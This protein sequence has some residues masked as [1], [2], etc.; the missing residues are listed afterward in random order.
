M[1]RWQG[2]MLHH[3][4]TKDTPGVDRE[5]FKRYHMKV[6]RWDDIG[7]HGVIEEVNGV[8]IPIGGRP[9]YMNG[10]HCPAR[11]NGV[12][13][14]RTHLGLCFAGNFDLFEMPEEQVIVGARQIASWCVMNDIETTAITRHNL[15]RDTDCPGKLFPFDDIISATN[16][17]LERY[18]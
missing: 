5:Q 15:W 17:I 16:D 1:S 12:S 4:A 14:N 7:Y 3:S 18:A 6:R 8:Y 11:V 10:A 9:A 13:M 2:I